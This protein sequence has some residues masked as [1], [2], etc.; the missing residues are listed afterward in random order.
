MITALFWPQRRQGAG[1]AFSEIAQ[2]H[3]DFAI[4]A[5]AAE[6]V[7]A[8]DGS[9]S[10]LGL[11]LGGVES[12]PLA[13]DTARHIGKCADA[14]LAAQIAAEVALQ[15]NPMSDFKATADYRR[16]LIG[17]LG[18]QVLTEAFQRAARQ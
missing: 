14:D 17:A 8:A 4:V 3:G 16:A 1:Y 7:L 5:S 18:A 13:I 2:R 11:G 9:I 10:Y 12:R 6:V 15:V